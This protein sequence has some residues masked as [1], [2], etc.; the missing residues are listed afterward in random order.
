MK[1]P[2]GCRLWNKP[3]LILKWYTDCLFEVVETF[4]EESHWRRALLKCRE[5][6]QLY[7]YEFHEEI[8]W[9]GGNDPQYRTYIPVETAEE[10][11]TL[12]ETSTL[13]LLAFGPRLQKD[14]PSD[15]EKPRAYWVG[16]KE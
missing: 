2:T 14:W 3:E 11:T 5:C 9:V 15:A 6:G 7:F 12:K 4:V 10:I 1:A 13:E 8:D 16:K